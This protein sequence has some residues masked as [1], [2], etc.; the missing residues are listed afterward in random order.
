MILVEKTFEEKKKSFCPASSF[1]WL[2]VVTQ[3]V[4]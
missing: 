4:P 1:I 2:T 3:I